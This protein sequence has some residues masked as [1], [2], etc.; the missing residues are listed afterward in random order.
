M[1]Q[2]DPALPEPDQ[3]IDT[4][5]VYATSTPADFGAL[6]QTAIKTDPDLISRGKEEQVGKS[7]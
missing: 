1:A 4:I 6:L 2:P 7:K 3:G 5:V